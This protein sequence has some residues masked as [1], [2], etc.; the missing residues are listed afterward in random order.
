MAKEP[1]VLLWDIET[2]LNI[3]T[4]F[5]LYP[6]QRIPYSGLLQE[7][8]IISAAFKE[9][10]K[11]DV[12]SYSLIDHPK[13]FRADPTDDSMLVKTIHAELS[14]ADAVIA[15]FG[16][17]FDIKF[18]N[19]RALHHGLGPLPP[20][21]QIDTYKMAKNKFLFNSNR[22]DYLGKFLGVGAKI[23]TSQELWLRALNGSVG[24]VE[25]MVEYNEHDVV[26]LEE[27]YKK[28]APFCPAHVNRSLFSQDEVCPLCGSSNFTYEGN[29][30]SATRM[31]KRVHCKDCGK[32]SQVARS[33]PLSAAKL[34]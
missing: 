13:H 25:D 27:V 24:A 30:Y 29:R 15:H 26:L 16:D 28:L 34:K 33:I 14:T 12:W 32:W 31:Y 22:L 2:G 11:G 1:R 21:I 18:F 6:Q 17:K 3:A 4:V 5:N 23:H 8:Y 19:T 20:L 9:L 10:G 7:R